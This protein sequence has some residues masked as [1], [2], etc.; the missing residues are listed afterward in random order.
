MSAKEKRETTKETMKYGKDSMRKN[1]RSRLSNPILKLS[2]FLVRVYDLWPWFG[3]AKFSHRSQEVSFF[4]MPSFPFHKVTFNLMGMFVRNFILLP[5][6]SEVSEGKPVFRFKVTQGVVT[7]AK[8]VLQ[9][10]SRQIFQFR[11]QICSWGEIFQ[12]AQEFIAEGYCLHELLR[13]TKA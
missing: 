3:L 4:H 1:V 13:S 9:I 11:F 8:L 7:R 5:G 12:H 2:E 6:L 10:F